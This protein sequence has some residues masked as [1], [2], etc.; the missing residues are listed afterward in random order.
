MKIHMQACNELVYS[1]QTLN[2]EH[3]KNETRQCLSA[4]IRFVEITHDLYLSLVNKLFE[5]ASLHYAL[6]ARVCLHSLKDDLGS[7]QK[8]FKNDRLQNL[9]I[10]IPLDWSIG[11]RNFKIRGCSLSR[12]G[13][14]LLR[15]E[16]LGR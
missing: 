2:S 11:L 12:N 15:W 3:V 7:T 10:T 8:R 5:E 9:C 16:L 1:K 4:V 13:L 6:L 14:T